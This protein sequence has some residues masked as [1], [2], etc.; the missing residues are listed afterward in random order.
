VNIAIINKGYLSSFILVLIWYCSGYIIVVL[1]LL[2]KYLYFLYY[3]T[4]RIFH[5]KKITCLDEEGKQGNI[6][7]IPRVVYVREISAMQLKN[8]F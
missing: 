3:I 2:A 5:N 4:Y 6:E 7:G 1:P 8:I